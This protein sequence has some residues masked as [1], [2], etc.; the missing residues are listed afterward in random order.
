MVSFFLW[1]AFQIKRHFP[2]DLRSNPLART[3][4]ALSRPFLLRAVMV[5]AEACPKVVFTPA[6]AVRDGPRA[7]MS[8]PGWPLLFPY[9]D[10]NLPRGA[11][12]QPA[13]PRQAG[14]L[15]HN[16]QGGAGFRPAT[17]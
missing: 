4:W 8:V 15:L 5:R 7:S 2:F 16:S 13:T 17:G 11:G 1:V 10:S 14:S 12:F 9:L 3:G 6:L